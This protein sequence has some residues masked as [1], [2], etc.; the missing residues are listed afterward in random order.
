MLKKGKLCGV[1]M[2]PCSSL[3]VRTC[4]QRSAQGDWMDIAILTLYRFK[5]KGDSKNSKWISLVS[6]EW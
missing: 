6:V 3:G 4:D 1:R 2:L 5:D